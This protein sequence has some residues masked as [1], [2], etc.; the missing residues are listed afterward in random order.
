M[1]GSVFQ[2]NRRQ[3]HD[4]HR[5]RRNDGQRGMARVSTGREPGKPQCDHDGEVEQQVAVR[6]RLQ[7]PRH[8][9]HGD[10][11]RAPSVIGRFDRAVQ[12]QQRD[13]HP[14]RHQ[15][16]KMCRLSDPV[17]VEP[18]HHPSHEPGIVPSGQAV[19]EGVRGK[20]AERPGCEEQQVIGGGRIQFPTRSV[21][22]S[23]V[24]DQPGVQR[25]PAHRA[26]AS[27]RDHSTSPR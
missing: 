3:R 16:L 26:A 12:R 18:K 2:E 17:G 21:E 27:T 10:P 22:R 14:P 13:R 4:G 1:D 25:M 5:P 24:R 11:G 20:G 8:R 19:R 9:E 6:Q 15:D 23:A 7:Q